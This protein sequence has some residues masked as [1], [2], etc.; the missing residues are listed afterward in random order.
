MELLELDGRA[1][2]GQLLRSALTLSLCTGAGFLMKG[3]RA[4]RSRPGLMRQHLTAVQAARAISGAEVDGATLGSTALRFVPGP[5]VAGDYNLVIGTAG[6]TMLVLQTLLPALW[7]AGGASRLRLEGGTHNP[8]A[9]NTDFIAETY[10]PALRRMGVCAKVELESHGFYPAG[11]GVVI[12]TVEKC[13]RLDPADFSTRG[14]LVGIRATALMSALS[15]SIGRR[16]LNVLGN[17]LELPEEHLELCSV[18]PAI[19]PGNAVLVRVEHE[20]HVE[21]FSGYGERG[22][23]AEKIAERVATAVRNYIDSQACVSEHLADQLLLPMALAGGG[24]LTTC[25]VSDHLTSNAAL[26]EKFL[27]VEITWEPDVG[28]AWRVRLSR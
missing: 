17:H 6:S 9:P 3:I 8:L 12:A 15:A 27:P 13:T 11:G 23:P 2:G 21:I 10:L 4:G 1:G 19:G 22:V 28:Q 25:T 26:I 18:R 7:Q 24:E 5:V 14:S 20:G 16:E